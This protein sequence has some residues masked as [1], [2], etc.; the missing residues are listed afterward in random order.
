M[1][2]RASLAMLS[3]I[4]AAWAKDAEQALRAPVRAGG[5]GSGRHKEFLGR[6]G[7]VRSGSRYGKDVYSVENHKGNEDAGHEFLVAKDGSWSHYNSYGNHVASGKDSG[8]L[9]AHLSEFQ[10]REK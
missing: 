9:Q 1:N 8:S 3:I 5:P 2:M 4:E 6:A 10:H 7:F